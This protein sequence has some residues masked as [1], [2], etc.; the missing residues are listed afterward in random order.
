MGCIT[1]GTW[2]TRELERWTFEGTL[3][4]EGEGSKYSPEAFQTVT[5]PCCEGVV[6]GMHHARVPEGPS[7]AQLKLQLKR[8]ID[9][10][11]DFVKIR[12][13]AVIDLIYNQFR[14]LDLTL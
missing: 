5:L 2:P 14:S 8:I 10:E 6:R 1:A 12:V 9:L 3:R 13:E 4:W 11:A 7:P